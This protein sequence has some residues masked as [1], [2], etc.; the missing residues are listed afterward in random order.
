MD[1][2]RN[3][4]SYAFLE[5]LCLN[6]LTAQGADASVAQDV[7]FSLLI[8][9]LRGIDSHGLALLPKILSRSESGRSQMGQPAEVLGSTN[10]LPMA[11]VDAHLSP[12]QH[13][14]LF[15]ARV[16]KQKAKQYGVGLVTVRDSTHFGCCT[17]FIVE[18]LKERFIAFVGSNSARS[19]AAFGAQA[20]NL[21]NNPFGVGAP[22]QGGRDF[23]FDSSSAVMSFGNL[24]NYRRLGIP[25]PDNA[26]IRPEEAGKD[27]AVY[28]IAGSLTEV[29]LPFGHYKGASVA[30]LIEIFSGLLS[31]GNFGSRTETMHN[32]RFPRA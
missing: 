29:A 19:M 5:D 6:L 11:V 13:A 9:S 1:G 14:C 16:A 12:G 24:A 22:V 18:V 28:E 20:A 26:F 3:C 21:G 23:I 7:T 32:D 15:S 25:V 17:P 4:Y 2:E 30:M 8:S 27:D 10:H 31:L